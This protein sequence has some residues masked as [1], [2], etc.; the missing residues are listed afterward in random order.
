MKVAVGLSGGVDSSV[1]AA[2]LKE[3]GHDVIGLTM[4]IWDREDADEGGGHA[5]YGPG[6]ARDIEEARQV[7]ETLEIPFHVFDLGR[8]YRKTVLDYFSGEY[9]KGRTPNPCLR[10]NPRMKFT[11]LPRAAMA[12]GLEFDYF[13]TGHYARI[14]HDEM[15]RHLL[16]RALDRSKDQSYG[17]IFLSREQLARTVL[18][19]GG[20]TKT[21]VRRIARNIGLKTHDI[22]DSQD[23]Y[24]GDIQDLIAE[25]DMEG[26][27]LDNTGRI[28]GRHNGIWHFTIG[29]RRGLRIPADRPMYVREIDTEN[30]AIIVG[31]RNEIFSDE[32]IAG[33]LNFIGIDGISEPLDAG[34]KIR[35]TPDDAEGT[36]M[37]LG[38]GRLR[39]KFREPQWAITPGQAVGFYDGDTVLGG[40]IIERS[41]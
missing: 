8:E 35:H 7:A 40:G 17:L 18:P 23:F 2:I 41:C 37:P 25:G 16:K 26:Q 5:C 20:I 3:Q 6:E 4:K 38:G 9:R 34:I 11:A 30:N 14:E 1:A 19:L 13:A 15:G 29:Q 22:P 32:L 39:V 36:I 31:P 12:S 10:C 33:S 28:L 27:I 24:S 21:E